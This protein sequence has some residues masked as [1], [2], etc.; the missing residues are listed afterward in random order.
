MRGAF[1][2]ISL[3]IRPKKMLK[4]YERIIISQKS[5]HRTAKIST[6]KILIRTTAKKRDKRVEGKNYATE[7]TNA[8][9]QNHLCSG[10]CDD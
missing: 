8:A 1:D 3:K 9:L 7:E 4:K 2:Q 6:Q 5:E 10:C